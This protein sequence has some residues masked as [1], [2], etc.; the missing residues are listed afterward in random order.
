MA[1]FGQV[2]AE[3]APGVTLLRPAEVADPA[4]VDFVL[5]FVPAPDAFRPYP[6]LRAIFSVGAGTDGIEGCPSRPG[7]VP[8]FRVEEPDQA[9]QM[10]GFAAFHVLWHH[11]GMGNYVGYQSDATWQR[12]LGGFSPRARRIGILGMGH[13]GQGIARGLVALGYPVAGYARRPPATPVAG[14]DHHSG[15]SLDL[16]LGQSDILI[17]VLPLTPQTDGMIDAAMLAR[18]PRGAALIHLGRGGQVDEGALLEAIDA[19]HLSGASVDVFRTEP[20]PADH[21][22][23][24]HPRILVTPHVAS[25]PEFA[26]VVRSVRDRLQAL[27]DAPSRK[28][29]A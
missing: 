24:A 12:N 2:F 23:W 1:L 10:A 9:L 17:N 3:H 8:V 13:M 21:P 28:S 19:G 18:L 16:F 20:L 25:I 7:G 27:P 5:T 26:D 29:T 14:V 22:F 4:M 11:R 6:N 15:D